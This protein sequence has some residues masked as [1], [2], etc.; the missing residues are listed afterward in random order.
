MKMHAVLLTAGVAA[1]TFALIAAFQRHV[2]AIPV[3]GD[4]L[5]K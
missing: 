1:A 2:A 5:P 3:A 4:Y